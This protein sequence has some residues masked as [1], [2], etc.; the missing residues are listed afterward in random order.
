MKGAARCGGLGERMKLTASN[1]IWMCA[2]SVAAT[3]G[4]YAAITTVNFIVRSLRYGAC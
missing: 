2:K 1:L 3:V 4:A